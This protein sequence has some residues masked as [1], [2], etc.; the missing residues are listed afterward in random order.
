MSR[1][2]SPIPEM[3]EET[4]KIVESIDVG[5][6]H[7]SAFTKENVQKLQETTNFDEYFVIVPWNMQSTVTNENSVQIKV[8]GVEFNSGDNGDVVQM[9]DDV[10]NLKESKDSKSIVIIENIKVKTEITVNEDEDDAEA[11]I[12]EID[13]EEEKEEEEV[14]EDDE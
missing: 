14:N 5:D 10:V 11:E 12:E 6:K 7:E 2:S 1:S 8:V 4:R 13:D 9:V 3:D